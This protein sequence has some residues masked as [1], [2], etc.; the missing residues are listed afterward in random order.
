MPG[1]QELVFGSDAWQV[2]TGSKAFPVCMTKG[3]WGQG[4]VLGRGCAHVQREPRP[5]GG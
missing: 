4:R 5:A 1:S 2:L 3:G